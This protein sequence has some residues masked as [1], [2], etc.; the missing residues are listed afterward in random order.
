MRSVVLQKAVQDP[1][2]REYFGLKIWVRLGKRYAYY[3]I[4]A[5]EVTSYQGFTVVGDTYKGAKFEKYNAWEICYTQEAD[6]P[7]SDAEFLD[8]ECTVR[9]DGTFEELTLRLH[10]TSGYAEGYS[11][12][13]TYQKSGCAID[14]G[15]D[16]KLCFKQLTGRKGYYR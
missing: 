12:P 7:E 3:D 1:V 2:V 11:T 9:A 15:L 10:F 13:I 5:N 8:A 4:T 6:T 14:G 16:L